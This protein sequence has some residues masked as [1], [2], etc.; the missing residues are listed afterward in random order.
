MPFDGVTQKRSISPRTTL[1]KQVCDAKEIETSKRSFVW[2]IKIEVV[3]KPS[4]SQGHSRQHE[5]VH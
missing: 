4:D 1:Q 3:Q 5:Y 2:K